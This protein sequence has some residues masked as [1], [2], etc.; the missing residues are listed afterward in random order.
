MAAAQAASEGK[1][2][3]KVQVLAGAW[4][5]LYSTDTYLNGTDT[6]LSSKVCGDKERGD[7]HEWQH[8]DVPAVVVEELSG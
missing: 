1:W 7:R 6:G 5:L 8:Q 4:D 3:C 2:D